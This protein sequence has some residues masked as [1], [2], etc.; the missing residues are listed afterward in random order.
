MIKS[1]P[2]AF[3]ATRMIDMLRQYMEYDGVT[4]RE[5]ARRA[6]VSAGSVNE[7]FRGNATV[8]IARLELWAA[9]LGYRFT[10]QLS[11]E[12]SGVG[13]GQ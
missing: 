11:R 12:E 8:S 9:V 7:V 6:G 2:Q 3:L 1:K 4:Q 13:T 10:V 5:L